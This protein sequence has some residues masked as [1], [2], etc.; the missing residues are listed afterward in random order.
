MKG[1]Y[2]WFKMTRCIAAKSARYSGHA[3]QNGTGVNAARKIYAARYAI[4]IENAQKKPKKK[5]RIT[6]RINN[7]F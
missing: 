1:R 3:R 5:K 4:F 7:L 2:T 6:L